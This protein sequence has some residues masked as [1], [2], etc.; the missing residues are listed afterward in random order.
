[1]NT[2]PEQEA[3]GNSLLVPKFVCWFLYVI[4]LLLTLLQDLLGA[5]LVCVGSIV[6]IVVVRFQQHRD[7]KKA[8]FYIPWQ[9]LIFGIALIFHSG[10]GLEA[11]TTSGSGMMSTV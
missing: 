7:W 9:T 3:K 4:G 2:L 5:T 1:M 11:A 10:E 6:G 8:I